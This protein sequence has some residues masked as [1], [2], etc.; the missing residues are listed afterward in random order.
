[1]ILSNR[2]VKSMTEVRGIEGAFLV[3]GLG[4]MAWPLDIVAI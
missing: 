3:W 2:A 4:T 1:M